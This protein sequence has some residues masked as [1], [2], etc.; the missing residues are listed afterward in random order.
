MRT[1]NAT[2]SHTTSAS[3][4]QNMPI[5]PYSAYRQPIYGHIYQ[6]TKR[7]KLTNRYI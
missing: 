7:N 6:H 1:A 2:R 4:E 3:K 5:S